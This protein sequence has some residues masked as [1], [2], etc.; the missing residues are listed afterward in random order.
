MLFIFTCLGGVLLSVLSTVIWYKNKNIIEE[1]VLGI[2]MW[3]FSHVFVSMGLFVLDKY[4]VF[5]TAAG[6]AALDLLILAAVVFLRRPKPFRL[7]KLISC[8]LSLKPMLIPIIVSLVAVPFVSLKNEYFGMGQDEGVYQTQAIMFING[9]TKKVKDF[10]EYYELDTNDQKGDFKATVFEHLRGYDIPSANFPLKVEGTKGKRTAGLM[11]GIPTYSAF[12]ATW[13]TIFGMEDM[14]D[15][16]TIFY[17]CLIFLVYFVC[18]NLKLKNWS[19]FCACAAAAFAPVVIWVAKSALTEIFLAL[20]PLAFLYFM[21][22]D[23]NPKQKWFSIIPIAVFGCY[24][25]SIYTVLPLFVMVYA[26]MFVFTREKQYAILMP[27]TTAGYLASFYM[28]RH[29]QPV[30]TI[31]NYS[32]VF[33][34]GIKDSNISKY[35]TAAA[36]IATVI[37]AIFAVV[38]LLMTKKGF[39]P[40]KF[41]KK[42][43]ENKWFNILLKLMIL[44]PVLYIALKAFRRYSNW[45]Q[46]NNL[47]LVGFAGNAG[48]LLLPAGIIAGFI[49]TKSLAADHSRLVL[50]LMFFYCILVYSTFLRYEIQY[51][52]YYSR[53][54]APF[55][56]VAVIFSVTVLDRFGAKLLIP[57]TAVGLCYEAKYDHYLLNN[58]DDTRMEWSIIDD[59]CDHIAPTD[60]VVI[61]SDYDYRLWLPIKNITGA[62]VFPEINDDENQF[63]DLLVKYCR[64]LYIA[65]ENPDEDAYATIYSNK[66]HHSEDDTQSTGKLV[67]MSNKFYLNDETIGLYSYGKYNLLYTAS[68]NYSMFSGVS[69]LE[70]SFCWTNSEKTELE[71][72][73]FPA[74]YDLNINLANMLPLTEM[75]KDEV[76]VTVF[77]N[78]EKVGTDSITRENNGQPLHYEVPEELVNDSENILEITVPLWNA[79]VINPDDSRDLGIPINSVQFVP[80]K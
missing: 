46:A 73:L 66:L 64:V 9:N 26:G 8:D 55:I 2:L 5:R 63:K 21:T 50:F 58:V 76:E 49:F 75:G 40:N 34:H 68:E 47:T 42:A 51:Y 80:V 77:L 7:K 6:A 1:I 31:N 41:I 54:L 45:D 72:S 29:V 78:G 30:Y 27:L 13:G 67:P 38:L 60:C 48:I 24:H 14:Q 71:C 69:A 62:R 28:M 74:T 57:L 39:N 3:L 52:Y 4:T 37:L 43:A 22:D 11:H 53:Y 17:I 18:K 70:T 12:L 19:S 65:K 35:V 56:S 61:S 16:E 44:M 23:Q 36:I 79:S 10:N 20:L 25:V 59:L 33:K 15:I 32:P